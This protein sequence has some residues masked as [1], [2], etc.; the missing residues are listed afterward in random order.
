MA[1]VRSA[2]RELFQ[3]QK[4]GQPDGIFVGGAAVLVVARHCARMCSPSQTA[5]TMLVLP[6]SMASSMAYPKNTSPA[7][8]RDSAPPASRSISAPSS[9]SVFENAVHFAI[10]QRG[11]GCGSPKP[12]R[13]RQPRCAHGRESRCCAQT[14]YHAS[15]CAARRA[16]TS[17]GIRRACR[18]RLR[19]GRGGK[20]G[21]AGKCGEIDAE[22]DGER[23]RR[24][25]SSRMPATLRPPSSTSLG[26]LSVTPSAKGRNR[27]GRGERRNEAKAAPRRSS[28]PRRRATAAWQTDCRAAKPTRVRAAHARRSVRAPRSTAAPLRPRRR[29]GVLLRWWNR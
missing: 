2:K 3:R 29:G 27:I 17:A 28:G 6:A 9:S 23:R 1:S 25:D 5:K 14:S 24:H 21:A 26:H 19:N 20:F 15:Q 11:P 16:S 22:T 18:Q 13:A 4:F 7:V 12:C 8:M 10:H